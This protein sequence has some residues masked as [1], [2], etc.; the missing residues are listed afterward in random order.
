MQ[1]GDVNW[2]AVIVSVVAS[3]G[4]GVGWYMGLSRQWMA[5]AGMTE[6]QT[7]DGGF[8][9]FIFGAIC[10]LFTAYMLAVFIVP[11]TGALTIANGAW[12]G[13]CVWIG[14][15][16]PSMVLNHRYQLKPWSLTIIDGGYMLGVLVLQGV[17]IG[18]FG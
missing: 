8:S 11:L 17:I 1:F 9:P 2:I 18:A 7:R 6:A 5:A 15:V 10:Q 3:M 12:V 16:L 4:L 14:F 13:F